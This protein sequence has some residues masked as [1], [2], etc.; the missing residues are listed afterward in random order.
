MDVCDDE[1]QG[2]DI[3]DLMRELAEEGAQE[4]QRILDTAPI[5]LTRARSLLGVTSARCA[6]GL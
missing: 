4:K 2:V 6:A 3:E 1:F 5:R